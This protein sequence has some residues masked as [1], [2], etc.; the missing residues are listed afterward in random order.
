[1]ELGSGRL[2]AQEQY[3]DVTHL[4]AGH[5]LKV[6]PNATREGN[7]TFSCADVTYSLASRLPAFSDCPQGYR[8]IPGPERRMP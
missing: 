8:V 6:A 7:T 3:R 2:I 1:M 5:F 4:I